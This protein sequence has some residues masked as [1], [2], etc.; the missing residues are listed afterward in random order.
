M[1]TEGDKVFQDLNHDIQERVVHEAVNNIVLDSLCKD[2]SK[3]WG[4]TALLKFQQLSDLVN[5]NLD[6]EKYVHTSM[7][8]KDINE[9]CP[10]VDAIR[11]GLHRYLHFVKIIKCIMDKYDILMNKGE[12]VF[13]L[14]IKRDLEGGS[15][16]GGKPIQIWLLPQ[17]IVVAQ[18]L[19][20]DVSKRSRKIPYD[21]ADFVIPRH[22][23]QSQPQSSFTAF[24]DTLKR[25]SQTIDKVRMQLISYAIT[26][27][28]KDTNSPNSRKDTNSPIEVMV[29]SLQDMVYGEI[30]SNKRF[31]KQFREEQ[32]VID[33]VLSAHPWGGEFWKCIMT[34]YK[35]GKE[36]NDNLTLRERTLKYVCNKYDDLC[37]RSEV[38]RRE[39]LFLIDVPPGSLLLGPDAIYVYDKSVHDVNAYAT[40]IF[41]M[42]PYTIPRYYPENSFEKLMFFLGIESSLNTKKEMLWKYCAD[43]EASNVDV[44]IEAISVLETR[45]YVNL[46]NNYDDPLRKMREV[47]MLP[48]KDDLPE[49]YWTEQANITFTFSKVY[50]MKGGRPTCVWILGRKRKL[51]KRECILMVM[52]KGELI[53][54]TEA[55]IRER[56]LKKVPNKKNTR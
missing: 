40:S 53:T 11:Y 17:A 41:D 37:I 2:N 7:S 1:V 33:M 21:C 28:R 39:G 30:L 20:N 56:Q 18:D 38:F 49:N 27:S 45:T 47:L 32:H 26:D 8:M 24:M 29:S 9:K 5:T 10:N 3:S 19:F 22:Y 35:L 34:K 4:P 13:T 48:K 16:D 31:F 23:I 36:N 51:V 15:V 12:C 52:Y 46:R 14:I 6:F 43:E 42:K 25:P 54:L 44:F 50:E 55:R